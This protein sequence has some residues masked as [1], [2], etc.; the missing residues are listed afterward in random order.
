VTTGVAASPV[1]REQELA[2][3]RVVVIGGSAG[4]GLEVERRARANGAE[5][6]LSGRDRD[7][8]EQA[9]DDLGALRSTAFDATDPDAL[10]QW[11]R[12]TSPPWPFT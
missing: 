8:L 2:G 10:A 6:I 3:Q 7:R 11:D 12:L 5:V 9:A 1:W 4:I